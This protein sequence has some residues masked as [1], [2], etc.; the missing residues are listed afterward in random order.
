[1]IIAD[2][3][4]GSAIALGNNVEFDQE[5]WSHRLLFILTKLVQMSENQACLHSCCECSQ[6]STKLKR[7]AEGSLTSF[8]RSIYILE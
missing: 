7:S 1:M 3:H 5:Y 2:S 4:T 6:N 8:K